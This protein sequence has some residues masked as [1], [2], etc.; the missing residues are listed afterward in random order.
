MYI[1]EQTHAIMYV[2]HV[3]SYAYIYV[4]YKHLYVKVLC[5]VI[6]TCT[7][8]GE[9]LHVFS[10]LIRTHILQFSHPTQ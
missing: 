5:R 1:Y 3:F 6:C 7:L 2:L 9:G 8:I 4:I 10:I